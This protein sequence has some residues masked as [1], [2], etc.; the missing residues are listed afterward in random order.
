MTLKKC[1]FFG[2][3][4]CQADIPHPPPPFHP[5]MCAKA[6]FKLSSDEGSRIYYNMAYQKGI[7]LGY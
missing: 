3:R 6:F 7:K 2:N 1:L 4:S 5:Q